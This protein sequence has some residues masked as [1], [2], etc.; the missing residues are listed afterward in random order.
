M[1]HSDAL[2]TRLL[3][4]TFMLL[5]YTTYANE[6]RLATP[7]CHEVRGFAG[8]YNNRMSITVQT[9]PAEKEAIILIVRAFPLALGELTEQWIQMNAT[10]RLREGATVSVQS[11]NNGIVMIPNVEAGTDINIELNRVRKDGPV[12]FRFWSYYANRPE[13]YI[14]VSPTNSFLAP[15]PTM[16]SNVASPLRVYFK[17]IAPKGAKGLMVQISNHTHPSSE[18]QFQ[19]MSTLSSSSSSS[20]KGTQNGTMHKSGDIFPWNEGV[21]YFSFTPDISTH[22]FLLLGVSV[23]WTDEVSDTASSSSSNT[24]RPKGK[25]TDNS[26]PKVPKVEKKLSNETGTNTKTNNKEKW[27]FFGFLFFLF[28]II[29]VYFIILSVFNYRVKGI[30]EF[31]DM[32]PHINTIRSCSQYVSLVQN[33]FR[34]GNSRGGYRDL[35]RQEMSTEDV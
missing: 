9:S 16:L 13:C 12:P 1:S 29:S 17:S 18:A 4:V 23:V 5:V 24:Q 8:E 32:I 6:V 34:E 21:V 28:C 3:L 33:S 25:T 30:T 27:S 26:T 7:M 31:P 35:N 15:I 14:D 19:V 20:S 11:N 22:R 10:Y 2:F